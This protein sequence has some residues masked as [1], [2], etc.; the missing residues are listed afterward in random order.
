VE[1]VVAPVVASLGKGPAAPVGE[2]RAD[3]V[4]DPPDLLHLPPVSLQET[5]DLGEDSH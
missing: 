4:D 1:G 3:R 2:V 5:P